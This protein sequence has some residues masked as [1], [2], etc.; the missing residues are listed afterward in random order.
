MPAAEE[1][2]LAL[3]LLGV[4]GLIVEAVDILE[5]SALCIKD[6]KESVDT[7]PALEED[8]DMAATADNKAESAP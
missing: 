3:N 8:M 5:A 6:E 1:A 7:A 2:A 4:V